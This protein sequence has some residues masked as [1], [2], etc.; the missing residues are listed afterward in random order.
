MKKS[1]LVLTVIYCFCFLN[2]IA[3]AQTPN[4]LWATSSGGLGNDYGSSVATDASGNIYVAGVF[5]SSTITFGSYT[6]TNMGLSDVFLAKY[7]VNG[8]VLWA[9]SAGGTNDDEPTSVSVDASGNVYLAGYFN[10]STLTFGATSLTNAGSWDIFLTKYD[11]NGNVH[12]AKSACGTETDQALSVAVDV[13]GNIY[14]AGYFWST[15]LIFGSYTLTNVGKYDIFLTKYDANGNVLWAKS[16]GGAEEE[17]ALSVAVDVSG[18]AYVAGIFGSSTISFGSTTLTNAGFDDIFL[19]KYD[20]NGNVLW[21]KSAGGTDYDEMGSVAADIS[22]NIYVAGY[23]AS[24]TITFGSTTLT[25]AGW[26]DMFLAKYDA[27]GNVLWA[28][29]AG[30]ADVEYAS[31]AAADASGNIFVA[32]SF[33]G[34]TITF[35]SIILT[36]ANTG[37]ADLFFVKYDINGN[38]LWAKSAGGT[39]NDNAGSVAVD[40]S[41]NPYLVGWFFSP[42]LPFSTTTLTN[43]DNTG[44][45]DDMFIAK[46]D[47]DVGINE[48]NN[49]LNISV[50]PNPASDKLTV[51]ISGN[52]NGSNLSL[53]NIEGQQIIKRQIT[54]PKTQLDISNLPSG[55]Y[56]VRLTGE[57]NVSVGKFIK[58]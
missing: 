34:S 20:V 8:N 50:Y 4:W 33:L 13:S 7:D 57:K 47:V 10:S 11:S 49:Q 19:A 16:A 54:E 55:V 28:K 26:N 14:M 38:V 12:W 21:A 41:G 51:E 45:T 37:G 29:S 24:P 9:K 42:T 5:A 39:G 30:G 17:Q 27:N 44:S 48:I 1:M 56:F 40:A 53:A 6:L 3:Y 58:Q 46:L 23:F 15:T 2:N 32:G 52:P 31:S 36:N 35:G 22:G 18:N 43:A 25:N